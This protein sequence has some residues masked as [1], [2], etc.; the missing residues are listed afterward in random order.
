MFWS[1]GRLAAADGADLDR[2][3]GTYVFSATD[4]LIISRVGDELRADPSNGRPPGRLLPRREQGLFS[5]RE[6]DFEFWFVD[7]S[8]GV[9]TEVVIT[10]GNGSVRRLRRVSDMRATAR[11][12]R[13][14][15]VNAETSVNAQVFAG[16]ERVKGADGRYRPETYAFGEGGF[17]RSSPVADESVDGIMFE[18]IV[19]MLAP[20]M[21][22]Q[23]YVAASD[24]AAT[25][26]AVMVYWGATTTDDHPAV[27][28]EETYDPLQHGARN[29]VNRVNARLLGFQEALRDLAG[30]PATFGSS[31]L[32]DL[33][34]DVEESRYWVALVAIDFQAARAEKVVK[35]RWAIR[36]NIR[37]RGTR[38]DQALPQMTHFAAHFFGRDSGGLVNR[39][40]GTPAGTV[41]V[42]EVVVVEDEVDEPTEAADSLPVQ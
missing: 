2:Y 22:A 11:S 27:I 10:G 30:V 33:T 18:Q 20:A 37:S 42:G 28:S 4:S 24:P 41:Q 5:L 15:A 35:P 9:V 19:Q 31:R 25:D 12:L 7:N 14:V 34:D 29:Q 26:L 38:F 23:N 3:A 21:E 32:N 36:Y 6:A 40:I 39:A 16:Y 8:D 1:M 13:A 17:Q